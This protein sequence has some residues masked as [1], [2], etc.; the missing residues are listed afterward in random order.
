MEMFGE[1][2]SNTKKLLEAMDDSTYTSLPYVTSSSNDG[3]IRTKFTPES[4]KEL[5]MVSEAVSALAEEISLLTYA[6]ADRALYDA[7]DRIAMNHFGGW[8]GLTFALIRLRNDVG[9]LKATPMLP[10]GQD[11]EPDFIDMMD[12]RQI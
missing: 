5:D 8:V 7:I 6:Y 12:E 10:E 11:S 2:E 1:T 4:L 3:M 9:M